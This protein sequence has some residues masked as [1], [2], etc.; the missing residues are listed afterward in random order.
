MNTATL[1]AYRLAKGWSR[2]ELA[3]R[4]GV[5]RQAVSLWFKGGHAS[6]RGEHLLR[7]AKALGVS[8]ER[9]MLPLPALT[10]SEQQAAFLWDELYPTVEAFAVAVSIFEERAVARFV[11]VEGLYPAEKLLGRRVWSRFESYARHIQPV[12]RQQL[13]RLV[14]WRSARVAS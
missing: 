8:M 6:V 4:A 12:R 9:L 2:S 5:S 11:Q 14:Q 10:S 7:L 3:R 1:D 13:E